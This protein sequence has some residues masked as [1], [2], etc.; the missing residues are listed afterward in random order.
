MTEVPSWGQLQ[1]VPPRRYIAAT[2]W[3]AAQLA[4]AGGGVLLVYLTAMRM[5][6]CAT[7]CNDDLANL[8]VD[9]LR[10]LL[11]A[12]VLAQIVLLVVALVRRASPH[13]IG[14]VTIVVSLVAVIAAYV[15]MVV[16]YPVNY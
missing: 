6:G 16:A 9:G 2:L 1:R 14:V 7:S 8:A 15:L 4:V 11:V 10:V 12:L 5:D 3:A 13:L